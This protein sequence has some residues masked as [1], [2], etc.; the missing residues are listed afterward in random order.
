MNDKMLQEVL[1]EEYK[2][3]KAPHELKLKVLKSIDWMTVAHSLAD[4]FGNL[5]SIVLDGLVPKND[6]Q[7]KTKNFF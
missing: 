1:N 5:P 3:I 6:E 4:L 7:D 2:K